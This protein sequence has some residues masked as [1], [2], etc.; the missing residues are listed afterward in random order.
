MTLRHVLERHGR[1][2]VLEL[3]QLGLE[4]L[5]VAPRGTSADVDDRERLADLHRRALHRAEDGDDAVGGLQQ[6]PCGW[7]RPSPRRSA[8]R[9]RRASPMRAAGGAGGQAAEARGASEAG[10]AQCG[11]PSDGSIL[12]GCAPRGGCRWR[13]RRRARVG[14]GAATPMGRRRLSPMATPPSWREAVLDGRTAKRASSRSPSSRLDVAAAGAA[15]AARRPRPAR[16]GAQQLGGQHRAR[17]RADRPREH[18]G[19]PRVAAAGRRPSRASSRAATCR[20]PTWSAPTAWPRSRCWRWAVAEVRAAGR[21]SR[22]AGR[23][24]RGRLGGRVRDRRRLHARWSPSAT[25]WS[26]S[27]G[28]AAPT[29][30]AAPPCR[31]CWPAAPIDAGA[32]QPPAALRAAPARTPRSSSGASAE[33]VGARDRR[34]G[35]GRPARAA[36]ADG[37]RPDRRLGAP[38]RRR[39]GRG[40]AARRHVA[41]G[42]PR[43][44]LAGFRSSHLEAMEARRVA[45]LLAVG[46]RSGPLRRRRAAGAADQGPRPGARVRPAHARPAGRR[47]RRDAA[48][49]RHAAGACSRRRAGPRRAAARLGV[50]ENTVAKRLRAIV[51]LLGED[52]AER[53]AD[54]L[55]ALLILRAARAEG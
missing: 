9:W 26:A 41:L 28:C 49:G 36:G 34:G 4:L 48:A 6:R 39:P 18:A 23:R 22:G 30:C 14:C 5:A 38:G 1:R 37:P 52:P 50:H 40:R 16:G 2:H 17:H 32:G 27:A 43:E 54:M 51:E 44:G 25:R 11:R 15:G 10:A 35:R 13:R 31:S 55:A 7:P 42:T 46:A 12:R 19:R 53:P 47:R 33:G 8:R 21:P 3:G 29:R 20:W 45:R 24:H